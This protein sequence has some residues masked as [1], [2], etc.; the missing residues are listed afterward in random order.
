MYGGA[1]TRE[2]TSNGH[3]DAQ[4]TKKTR[5]VNELVLC[6]YLPGHGGISSMAF[7]LARNGVSIRFL[8]WALRP[9]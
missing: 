5:T 6:D 8:S 3:L 2:T 9:F 7:A 4:A 1:V